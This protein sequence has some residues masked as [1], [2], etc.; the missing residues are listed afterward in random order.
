MEILNSTG[1]IEEIT[2][3]EGKKG[4][5]YKLK[6][7]NRTYNIFEKNFQT[8]EPIEAFKQIKEKQFTTGDAANFEY[9]E[10]DTGETTFKNLLK[11]F[12]TDK[13][14]DA[15]LGETDS[16]VPTGGSCI[17]KEPYQNKTGTQI[18]RMNALTNAIGFFELN[19]EV[20]A[21]NLKA[22]DVNSVNESM[23]LKLAE[24]FE[25]WV[26]R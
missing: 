24:K 11:L 14:D 13:T 23:V 22:A 18:A 9:T 20:V 5:F 3:K 6:I 8:G 25:T 26:T 12:E 1:V 17:K 15:K 4:T 21:I 16:G 7:E 2:S 10:H 19:K